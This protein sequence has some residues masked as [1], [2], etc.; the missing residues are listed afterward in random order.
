MTGRSGDGS[1]EANPADLQLL[2]NG[3]YRPKSRKKRIP[4]FLRRHQKS[5]LSSRRDAEMELGAALSV[6]SEW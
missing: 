6:G 1:F 3:R 2:D 4:P 5:I